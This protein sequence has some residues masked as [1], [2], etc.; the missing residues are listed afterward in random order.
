M[1]CRVGM[2]QPAVWIAW[3]NGVAASH[4]QKSRMTASDTASLIGRSE[5]ETKLLT[6]RQGD[7]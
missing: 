1:V 6:V 4:W 2:T 3:L 5:T 7:P